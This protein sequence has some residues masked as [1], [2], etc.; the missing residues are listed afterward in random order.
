MERRSFLCSTLLPLVSC[1]SA[2]ALADG[3]QTDLAHFTKYFLV[4]ERY[5]NRNK[6]ASLF[7]HEC[8]LISIRADITSAWNAKLHQ[9]SKSA[10]LF[11]EG[12][13]PET[14]LF[15]LQRLLHTTHALR[16]SVERVD[17]DFY[18]WNVEAINRNIDRRF[19]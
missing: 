10:S 13:T 11:V 19:S 9:A 2:L 1:P 14:T 17:Q 6:V 3:Q 7:Q 16:L 4:D 12:V 8:H 18:A 5:I 15:C